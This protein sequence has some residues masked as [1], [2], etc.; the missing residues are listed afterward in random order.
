EIRLALLGRFQLIVGLLSIL[1]LTIGIAGGLGLTRTTV[2]PIYDL[3]DAVQNTIATGRTD[4]RVLEREP[5]GDPV[6]QLSALFNAMLDRITT[7]ITAMRESLDNVA[8]DLRTPIARLRAVAERAL[9]SGDPQQQREA[10]A[11]CLEEA[12]RI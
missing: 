5:Q 8:H 12:Q 9:E 3:I 1:A 7:L 4:T 6:H 10:L 2:Q 11:D